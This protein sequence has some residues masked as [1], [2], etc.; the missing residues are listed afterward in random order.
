MQKKSA[1]YVMMGEKSVPPVCIQTICDELQPDRL[2]VF[3]ISELPD[4]RAGMST[5]PF[6]R[7]HPCICV[8]FLCVCRLEYED[9]MF[10]SCTKNK[11]SLMLLI[12]Q[13]W[14]G[15]T[16]T[17][18]HSWTS[19]QNSLWI[20]PHVCCS[21]FWLGGNFIFFCCIFLWLRSMIASLSSI[22]ISLMTRVCFWGHINW[23]NQFGSIPPFLTR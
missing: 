11:R 22:H 17:S 20:L 1:N 14:W 7:M 15:L 8:R 23:Q 4:T 19:S 21:A 16:I 13:A 9:R 10:D 3:S 6:P 12:T 2:L 18:S 5:S